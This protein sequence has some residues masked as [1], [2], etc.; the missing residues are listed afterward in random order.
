MAA[1]DAKP[2]PLKNTAFRVSFDIE[3][4]TNG[5][6]I[7]TWAGQDSE[8][9]LDGGSFTDCT[10]EATEI[11][12]TGIGYLDLTAAE[13]NADTVIVKV[14]VTNTNARVVR[15][16]FNPV[17]STDIPVNATAISGD[18]VAADNLELQFDGT[19]L[20]GNTYPATQAGLASV[21]QT[22]NDTY[23][24]VDARLPGTLSAGRMRS[25][26]ESIS[27]DVTAATNAEAFF[28]GTGYAGTNN[29]I[30]TVT[31]VTNQVTANMT[32]ISGDSV[33][34]DNLEA[35]F[36][37][38]G[39][40]GNTYPSTQL[41]VAGV[42]G[43]ATAAQVWTYGTRTLTAVDAT[44]NIVNPFTL[45]TQKITIGYGEDRTTGSPN[46]ALAL[47]TVASVDLEAVG[48]TIYFAVRRKSDPA[49]A[50]AL[51]TLTGTAT[52][53]LAYTV[54]LSSTYTR[55]LMPGTYLWSAWHLDA[56]GDRTNLG[57]GA[58]VVEDLVQPS[59]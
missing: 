45:S 19:G 46:G 50:D 51:F 28:D 17:E 22:A 11:G 14:T 38:T 34:A 27:S 23:S 1:S 25:D 29:V 43:G 7:T 6:L 4:V 41:Q 42:S 59:V 57:S 26:M 40:T 18:T 13:M 48:S 32:A 53:T 58:Y 15:L 44:V 3:N 33:A 9:S 5:A 55:Q 30:P 20:T 12:T 10:N 2:V 35:Q 16:Y 39:L 36:D 24:E 47:T 56:S 21:E 52:G 8:V 31:S 54:E 37:G 49:T